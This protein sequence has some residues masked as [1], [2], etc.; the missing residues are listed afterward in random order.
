MNADYGYEPNEIEKPDDSLDANDKWLAQGRNLNAAA[1][2]G[3]ILIGVFY[4]FMQVLFL[5]AG[6]IVSGAGRT[7]L[8]SGDVVSLLANSMDLFTTPIRW[9]LLLSEFLALLLPTIFLIKWWHTPRVR[10]YTRLRT[11]PI[12]EIMLAVLGTILIIPIGSFISNALQQYFHI[13]N[14]MEDLEAKIFA[15]HSGLEFFFLVIVVAVTPAICE[16]F[17]FRGYVQRT[18]ER[19]IGVHSIALAG[20]LF[21]LFHFEPL[22]LLTLTMIGIWLGYVYY[23]S[24]SLL[25]NM[26]AHFTNNFIALYLMYKAPMLFGVNVQSDDQIPFFWLLL[27]IPLLGAVAWIYYRITTSREESTA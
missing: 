14:N 13:N 27:T 2:G 18:F 23:R 8:Q 17:F 5:I 21:G 19:T 12:A 1:I 4:M 24:K 11:A 9:A 25:P 20:V 16:E 3:L 6:I 15:A 22:G 7:I 26:A 10:D